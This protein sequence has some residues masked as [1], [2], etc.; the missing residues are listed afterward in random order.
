MWS[1]VDGLFVFFIVICIALC[2]LSL[3]PK[4]GSVIVIA[5]FLLFLFR[6]PRRWILS[7]L[8]D[9]KNG[10]EEFINRPPN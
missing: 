7:V 8:V 10:W 9:M 3:A 1:F 5:L 2:L 4:T 6:K